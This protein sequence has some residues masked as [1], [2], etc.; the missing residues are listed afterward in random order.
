MHF[1]KN[2]KHKLN[3]THHCVESPVLSHQIRIYWT[4]LHKWNRMFSLVEISGTWTHFQNA[5][6]FCFH[7]Q[8]NH[9]QITIWNDND[10]KRTINTNNKIQKI[11]PNLEKSPDNRT[12]LVR[13]SVTSSYFI[14]CHCLFSINSTEECELNEVISKSFVPL[15]SP[16]IA[17]W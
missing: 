10:N 1:T 13:D 3:G 11:K 14:L 9:W 4:S 16:H 5:A 8:K 12:M 15:E 17:E 2:N 6:C 7:Q